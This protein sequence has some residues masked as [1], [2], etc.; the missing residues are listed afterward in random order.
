MDKVVLERFHAEELEDLLAGIGSG[1][2]RI[3]QL[4]NY[5]DTRYNKPTAEEEDRR[6]L[7]K[8]EQKANVPF[9]PKPKDHI[10]VEGWAT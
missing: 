5:L 2:I 7:E 9:R 8:L 3:N 6:L 1:D 4:L 10:V